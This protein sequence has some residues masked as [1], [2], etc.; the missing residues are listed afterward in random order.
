MIQDTLRKHIPITLYGLRVRF[1]DITDSHDIADLRSN[2]ELTPYMVTIEKDTTAQEAW[3]KEYKKRESLDLDY[4]FAYE[5]DAGLVGFNR[6]SKINWDDK[7]CFAASWIKK[8]GIKG[9][10]SQMFLARCE[11]A[12]NMMG[13]QNL[14]SEIFKDNHNVLKHWDGYGAIKDLRNDGFF[15]LNLSKEDFLKN[16]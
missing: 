3:I 7:S 6:L 1:V 15:V 5:D 12:F 11:I 9:Y 8:P 10:G 2:K 4:Y 16:K 14:Y 13:M